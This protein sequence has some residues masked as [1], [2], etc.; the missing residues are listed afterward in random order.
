MPKTVEGQ[1]IAGSLRFGIV[2]SRWNAVITEKLLAGA[3]DVLSRHGAGDD[4]VTVARVPGAWEIP[5]AALRMAASGEFDA[6]ICLGCLIRGETPHF[7][8]LSAEVTRGLGQI[9]LDS[10]IPVTY[11][12]L[13]VENLE[14]AMERAGSKAGNKG[15]EA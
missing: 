2:A 12:V 6:I 1:L 3:L 7:D 10:A 11:G 4:R 13:T 9:A 15:S 5:V 14:Q 8:Y